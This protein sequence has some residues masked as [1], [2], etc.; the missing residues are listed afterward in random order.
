MSVIVCGINA[1][2]GQS[3]IYSFVNPLVDSLVGIN[4]VLGVMVFTYIKS[5][6]NKK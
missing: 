6:A 1:L 3:C 2:G 5:K 4:L